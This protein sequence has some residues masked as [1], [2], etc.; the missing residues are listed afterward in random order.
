[1][2]RQ[3]MM[4][5]MLYPKHARRRED[6][7]KNIN[8]LGNHVATESYD[9]TAQ[10][11][12]VFNKLLRV[13]SESRQAALEFYHIHLPC[14]LIGVNGWNLRIL[15]LNPEYD[16]IHLLQGMRICGIIHNFLYDLKAYDPKNIGLLNLVI[17]RDTFCACSDPNRPAH[18]DPW[19]SRAADIA[20]PSVRAAFVDTLSHMQEVIVIPPN[21]PAWNTGLRRSRRRNDMQ[22]YFH[23]FYPVMAEGI[24]FDILNHDPRPITWSPDCACVDED[25]KHAYRIWKR[26]LSIWDIELVE[27]IRY[28]IMV[29]IRPAN[30]NGF[31]IEIFNY[32]DAKLWVENAHIDNWWH[33]HTQA[34]PSL[35]DH[36]ENHP[37]NDP[38][39]PEGQVESAFGFWLIPVEAFENMEND[40]TANLLD[41]SP[42]LALLDLS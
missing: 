16:F 7:E 29:A 15:Y 20:D 35:G 27:P 22:A 6:G 24:T 8:N 25:I 2:Q 17:D 26:L 32:E 12:Y 14:W 1:M 4:R 21:I 28:R 41:F 10:S 38:E 33:S 11:R 31:T 30:S 3:R 5:F 19:F 18:D 37:A 40:E 42:Q 36:E 13:T 39:A 34:A 23:H 9:A